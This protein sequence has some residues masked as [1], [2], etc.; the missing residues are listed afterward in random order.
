MKTIQYCNALSTPRARCFLADLSGQG[1]NE[2]PSR[3]VRMS[4]G[5]ECAWWKLPRGLGW[6][7]AVSQPQIALQQRMGRQGKKERCDGP[8]QEEKLTAGSGG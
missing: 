7:R 3:A 1:D 4:N 6:R 8:G 5:V 2:G